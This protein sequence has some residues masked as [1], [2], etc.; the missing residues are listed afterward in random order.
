M[1]K[2]DENGMKIIVSNVCF[3]ECI[4]LRCFNVTDSLS[5]WLLRLNY[6]VIEYPLLYL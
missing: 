1:S 2:N 5:V 3:E 6:R 4:Q